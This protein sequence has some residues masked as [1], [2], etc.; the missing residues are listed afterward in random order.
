MCEVLCI[1]RLDVPLI[2]KCSRDMESLYAYRSGGRDGS[3]A[4]GRLTPYILF[5]KMKIFAFH[6]GPTSNLVTPYITSC[7]R[8]KLSH[9]TKQGVQKVHNESSGTF[10][11]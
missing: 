1:H 6:H 11:Q 8:M 7:V 4:V 10:I 3:G 5:L 9:L 2:I